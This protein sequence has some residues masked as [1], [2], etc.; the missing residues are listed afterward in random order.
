MEVDDEN[1]SD[2][3]ETEIWKVNKLV[4]KVWGSS[5]LIPFN[6]IGNEGYYAQSPG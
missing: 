1:D 6:V 2:V 3:D 4:S 5:F